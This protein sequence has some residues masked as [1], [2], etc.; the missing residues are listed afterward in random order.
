MANPLYRMIADDLRGQIE[1]G[2]LQPGQQL[3]TE[4]ELVEHYGASRNTVR[5]AIRW[6][7]NLGLVETRPGQGTF[8]I[9]KMAPY[10]TTLTAAPARGL[11]HDDVVIGSGENTTNFE[12]EVKQQKRQPDFTDPEV[13]AEKATGTIAFQLR[14]PEGAPLISRHQKRYIDGTPWSLQTSFYPREFFSQG[15]DRLMDADDIPEGA[16]RYLAE[17]L[18]LRQ[19]GY[20]DWITVRSPDAA[21]AT[22]FN[23]PP[24]GR[25]GVF[26]IFRVGFDQTRTPMR[27][28]VTVFPTDRNQFV[29]NVGDVPP[30][31]ASTEEEGERSQQAS[32]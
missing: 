9:K 8:V 32:A 25:V 7:V 3:R 27:L 13:K 17:T 10:I 24:D 21:E 18:G 23:V 31:A 26:E 16:V 4:T 22:F 30:L 15:A 28:T 20:R 5:D 11:R 14:V 6:L 12:A 2:G 19:V 1:T 29:V